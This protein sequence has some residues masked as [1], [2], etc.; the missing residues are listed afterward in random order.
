MTKVF[1]DI[2]Q[3]IIDVLTA[4]ATTVQAVYRSDASQFSGY[5]AVTVSPSGDEADYGDQAK[6]KNIVTFILRIYQEIP[7]SGQDAAEIKLEGAVEQIISIFRVRNVLSGAADW[8]DPAPS[9]WG[10]QERET[11]PVRVVE[12]RLRCRVYN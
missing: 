2:R 5:P 3:K 7:Q 11:G 12:V 8:V 6:D 4:Q 1:Q 9:I 10:Y